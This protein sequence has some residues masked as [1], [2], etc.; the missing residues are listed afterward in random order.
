MAPK[1]DENKQPSWTLPYQLFQKY[2]VY[3][4]SALFDECTYEEWKDVVSIKD[5]NEAIETARLLYVKKQL[6]CQRVDRWNYALEQL[7]SFALDEEQY[8]AIDYILKINQINPV[9]FAKDVKDILQCKHSKINAL[10][11]W[12]V[13]NSGKT[14]LANCIVSPFVVCY[15]NNHGSENEFFMSNMLNKSIILC[16]ELYI[17]IATAEDLKSVLGGQPIDIAKKF[18]EKQTLKR[19]PVIITSNY[20]RFGRGHLAPTDENA[21]KLRCKNYHF[22]TPV[23][24]P[25]MIT[26]QQFYLYVNS[27]LF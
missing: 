2:G 12:G 11:L 9:T 6:E 22:R 3:S 18:L 1:K 20:E 7:D 8:H 16:E 25:C 5:Y 15:M 26:W 10:R 4:M 17:T 14:L 24:P 13:P 27:Q 21:L 23:S 19:T